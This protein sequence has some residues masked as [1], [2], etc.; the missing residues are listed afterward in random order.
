MI[1]LFSL[2][3]F[4]FL[5]RW[6]CMLE[7]IK[8]I[9]RGMG[10]KISGRKSYAVL[11]GC[12]AFLFGVV[13]HSFLDLKTNFFWLY[14]FLLVLAVVMILFR[15]DKKVRLIILG[16]F[17]VVAGFARFDLSVR[18]NKILPQY[19]G[20][21][22]EIMGVV[23]DEPAKKI[24]KQQLVIRLEE[25]AGAKFS[26]AEKVLV[27]AGL[28]PEYS[29][30]DRLRISCRFTEPKEISDFDYPR[31]LSMGDI[32]GLCYW[33]EIATLPA[34][35]RNDG[36]IFKNLFKFKSFLIGKVNGAM[37][38]PYASFLSG[39]VLG[40]RSAMPPRLLD[41]FQRAGIT[42]IIAISGWNISFLSFIF[43]PAFFYLRIRRGKA[44]YLMLVFIF[45]YAILTGASASVIR[46]AIMGATLLLAQKMGRLNDGGRALLYAAT[47]MLLINP[48][49][50]Y[51][52]GFYLSASAAFGLIYFAPIIDARLIIKSRTI[53]N[54]IS[55]TVTAVIFT[56]PISSYIFKGVSLWALPVNLLVLP[57]VPVA[58]VASLAG[59]VLASILPA[60]LEALGISPLTGAAGFAAVSLWPAAAILNYI[61]W[62]A[63]FFGRLPIGYLEWQMP[64]II[65]IAYYAALL[66]FTFKKLK[67]L[68]EIKEIL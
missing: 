44:F 61:I 58:F 54:Y 22:I 17:F 30:G 59:M 3:K 8:D 15:Q 2:H 67:E 6:F 24:D 21:D 19:F 10:E 43:L 7:Q 1:A 31:Y 32:Y 36:V 65:V 4:I 64:L 48:R 52:A 29:Y 5:I 66:F 25:I 14:N 41:D 68:Q 34:V 42:H 53:K 51:D 56:L 9:L 55:A 45:L 35:A 18:E 49:V 37:P 11:I 23:A 27:T 28:Y 26:G 16:A 13:I 47:I 50:I 40:A 33:P 57:F 12:F 39:L 63:G 20:R 60:P 38:E 46:A 62:I